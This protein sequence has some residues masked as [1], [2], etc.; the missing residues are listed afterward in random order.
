[1]G[2]HEA[3]LAG[4]VCVCFIA[5]RLQGVLSVVSHCEALAADDGSFVLGNEQLLNSS[6]FF[7]FPERKKTRN[8]HLKVFEWK[9]ARMEGETPKRPL[10]NRIVNERP[11]FF[12]LFTLFLSQP[13]A[14]LKVCRSLRGFCVCLTG[15][16]CKSAPALA[17]F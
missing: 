8:A 14:S 17:E 15:R 3:R 4:C 7:V 11:W 10:A 2:W 5:P 9:K 13:F 1:M 6:R 16:F 12:V